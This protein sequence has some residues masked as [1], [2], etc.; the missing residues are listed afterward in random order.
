MTTYMYAV[1]HRAR[2]QSSGAAIG[3]GIA[4]PDTLTEIP[5]RRYR[6]VRMGDCQHFKR[7][8]YSYRLLT[9]IF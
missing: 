3:G 5:D 8:D 6:S 2:S 9:S 4:T 7:R 1:V